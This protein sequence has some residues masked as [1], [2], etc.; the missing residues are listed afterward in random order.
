VRRRHEWC[1]TTRRGLDENCK[2][3]WTQVRNRRRKLWKEWFWEPVLGVA[4]MAVLM[5][6]GVVQVVEAYLR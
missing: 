4:A 1:N 6:T 2:Q 3:C 5:M